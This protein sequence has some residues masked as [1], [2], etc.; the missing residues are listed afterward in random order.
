MELTKKPSVGELMASFFVN[1]RDARMILLIA[2]IIYSGA[3]Q[4][5]IFVN[6]TKD[7]VGQVLGTQAIGWVMA[8]FGCVNVLSSLLLGKLTDRFGPGPAVALGWTTH[9]IFL[10]SFTAMRGFNLVPLS[11][12][13]DN[14]WFIYLSVAVY[15]T[16]DAAWQFFPPT[17]IGTLF[18]SN[19][20]AAFANFKFFQSLGNTIFSI[21]GAYVLFEVKV[22]STFGL[23]VIAMGCILVMHKRYSPF[24][25]LISPDDNLLERSRLISGST[26]VLYVDVT[27]ASGST[28]LYF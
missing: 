2:C 16:G 5:F 25:S 23:L 27:P 8:V 14:T 17:M 26:D 28:S 1:L 10:I 4:A 12:F 3:E 11:W 21:G 7:M 13:A 9:A 24:L 22:L 18:A 6:F 20:E 19:A 15:A